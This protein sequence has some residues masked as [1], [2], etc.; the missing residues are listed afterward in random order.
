MG[1]IWGR[2]D[3]GGPHVGPMNLAIWGTMA[4]HEQWIFVYKW[5][6][7]LIIWKLLENHIMNDHKSLFAA[8]HVSMLLV[9]T[10][11]WHI[12]QIN[13]WKRPL[14]THVAIIVEVDQSSTAAV[15]LSWKHI[16]RRQFYQMSSWRFPR[17][18]KWWVK[19]TNDDNNISMSNKC[20]WPK[21][22]YVWFIM[23]WEWKVAL[24]ILSISPG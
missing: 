10:R 8:R 5:G 4:C 22:G 13:Q 3:P 14:T 6:N 2:Q 7:S 11:A 20:P 24:I 15:L 23:M 21:I 9:H 16:L 17:L 18:N 12:T 19:V 1:P